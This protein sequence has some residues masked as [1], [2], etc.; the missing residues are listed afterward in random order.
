M[1]CPSERTSE[2]F[3]GGGSR[4]SLTAAPFVDPAPFVRC[5][6][7]RKRTDC[8]HCEIAV[9]ALQGAL[10]RYDIDSDSQ[11]EGRLDKLLVDGEVCADLPYQQFEAPIY[12]GRGVDDLVDYCRVLTH[13]KGNAVVDAFLSRKQDVV[14]E[15]CVGSCYLGHSEL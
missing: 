8:E 9:K 12:S 10:H 1:L 5:A 6:Q 2:R 4:D 15:V 14:K 11:L 13:E 7:H 3:V